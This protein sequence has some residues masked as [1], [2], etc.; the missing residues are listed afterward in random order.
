MTLKVHYVFS[1]KFELKCLLKIL[2][3]PENRLQWDTDCEQN[4]IIPLKEDVSCF[5]QIYSL[6]KKKFNFGIRDELSKFF[7]FMHAGTYY[8]YSSSV[9][10]FDP[11]QPNVRILSNEMA[12]KEAVRQEN[13]YT[14]FKIYRSQK[15][16]L[17]YMDCVSSLD[18]K[19]QVPKYLINPFIH[20]QARE[21]YDNIVKF[22]VKNHGQV[23]K[24]AKSASKRHNSTDQSFKMVD[25][26]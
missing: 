22:Y 20:K 23:D 7:G 3:D 18:T 4:E 25:P 8:R 9:H 26:N 16:S 5:G 24:K 6:K 14:C 21:K 17:I 2:F 15:D 13:I 12:H 11:N 10:D 19:T 1:R